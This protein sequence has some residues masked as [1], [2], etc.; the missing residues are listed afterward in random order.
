MTQ[1]VT[2]FAHKEISP[3]IGNEDMTIC[4][5]CKYKFNQTLDA[6]TYYGFRLVRPETGELAP[7][8]PEAE[9]AET[10]PTPPT[11]SPNGAESNAKKPVRQPST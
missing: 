1:C 7:M 3:Y 11:P 8:T 4:K 2:C 9:R 6:L 10:P 5:S